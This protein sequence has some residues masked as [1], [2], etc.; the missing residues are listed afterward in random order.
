[1]KEKVPVDA[2]NAPADINEII[3]LDLLAFIEE[4]GIKKHEILGDTEDTRYI[5]LISN[6]FNDYVT[7]R[8]KDIAMNLI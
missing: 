7:K 5:E 3:L 6:V 2:R 4:R 8:G 1:M